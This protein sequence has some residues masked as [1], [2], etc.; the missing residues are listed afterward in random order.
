VTSQPRLLL[1][2]AVQPVVAA[3]LGFLS[4]PLID[5]SGRL[6]EPGF[7]VD[8][9][10]AGMAMAFGL[11]IAAT[12]LTL[13]GALP[14]VAW[15]LSRGP[16]TRTQTLLAGAILGNVPFA[17]IVPLAYAHESSRLATFWPVGALRALVFGTFF[18]LAGAAVFWMILT[19]SLSLRERVTAR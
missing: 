11:A 19:R 5:F 7:P 3:V 18:G 15:C 14:A 17:V 9:L 12:L 1:G 8:R 16:L 2:L 10:D 6:L 13:F 4:F